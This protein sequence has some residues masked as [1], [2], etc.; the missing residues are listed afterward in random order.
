MPH[1][2]NGKKWS[3]NV[4]EFPQQNKSSAYIFHVFYRKLKRKYFDEGA[5][6]DDTPREKK[7]PQPD[8]DGPEL[9]TQTSSVSTR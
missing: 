3:K 4:I 1:W 7:M 8:A 2:R 9:K 5:D 6:G